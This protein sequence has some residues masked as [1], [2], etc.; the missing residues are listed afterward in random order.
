MTANNFYC[1]KWIAAANSWI[2]ILKSFLL[3]FIFLFENCS[4]DMVEK[5]LLAEHTNSKG[6]KIQ[7]YAVHP[8]ATANDNLQ[9]RVEEK[10]NP[11][12]ITE[13]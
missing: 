1:R 8:G 11:L 10:E 12:W 6:V 4:L 2:G 3:F 9:V 7:I 13:D 5:T